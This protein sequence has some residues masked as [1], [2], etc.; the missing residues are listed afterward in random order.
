MT[1][2]RWLWRL[3]I[4]FIFISLF[5][6]FTVSQPEAFISW[7]E[8]KVWTSKI[9]WQIQQWQHQAQDLPASVQF[10]IKRFWNKLQPLGG[11]KSV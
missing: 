9:V 7:P 6:M 8:K 1:K 3:M 10:E 11:G 4:L 2:M 5:K